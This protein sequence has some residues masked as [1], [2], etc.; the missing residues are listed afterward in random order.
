MSNYHTA[1]DGNNSWQVKKEGAIRASGSFDTQKEAM[2]Y[3]KKLA[4]QN[5]GEH[6]IHGRDGRIRERDSYGNDP[7]PPRG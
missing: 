7:F 5:K 2:D 4:K 6:V 3:G 1:P